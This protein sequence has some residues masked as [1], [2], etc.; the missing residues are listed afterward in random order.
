MTV[1]GWPSIARVLLP[2]ILGA[3]AVPAVSTA[4]QARVAANICQL[5]APSTATTTKDLG[6]PSAPPTFSPNPGTYPTP[7]C[8]VSGKTAQVRIYLKPAAQA[9]TEIAGI[10]GE[11]TNVKSRMITKSLSGLG[12]GAT[13]YYYPKGDIYVWFTKGSHFVTMI[14]YGATPDQTVAFAR[15]VGAELA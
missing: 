14:G 3:L 7:Y 1:R 4:A 8:T 12:T 2:A 11:F 9:A 5:A 6:K 13:L 10:E 15:A